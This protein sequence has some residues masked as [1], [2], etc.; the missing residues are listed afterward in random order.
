MSVQFI[1]MI[2]HQRASETIAPSGPIFDKA[3]IARFAQAHEQAGFDR[4]L[5][6]Y[7]SNQPDGFLVTALAGLSTSRIQFL[8]A[9]RPGFVAPT[10]AARKL[11][12]L[13]H[14]LDG[15]LALHV[16][17]GGSDVEQRKDGD[18]LDHDQR[19][20]RTE[21]FLD[22]LKRVWTSEQPFDHAGAL[23]RAEGA[24]SAI[25]PLQQP[26][27]PVY[28]GGASP[29]ALQV[30]GKHADVYAL[31]GESLEQVRETVA[32]VRAEAA[33]HGREVAFSVS[34]RPI[35]AATEEQAWAKAQTILEQARQRLSASGAAHPHKPDSVGA[36]RL[37]ELA[38]RGE[39]IDS[40]LWTGISK[41]VG[42]AYNSTALV[43]TPEQVADALLEYYDLGIRSFLIRGFDPLQDA[44]DYGRELIP[45]TRAKV[46]QREAAATRQYA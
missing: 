26:H 9:H 3:Y 32:K 13:D 10:L 35:V 38:E 40:R 18:Y 22:V 21:E 6:G 15:R 8:L 27:I 29:A 4:I 36:Q 11:A 45:L 14:L 41:L 44:I 30:A 16:I 31:W 28:F 34:F 37:R 39:R 12:T 19:Y 17:S 23:Y 1:G 2:G 25:K 5:V 7:W 46:A 33:R 24:G 43:G 20:A 42:G